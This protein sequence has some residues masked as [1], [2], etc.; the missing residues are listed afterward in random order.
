MR[1]RDFVDAHMKQNKFVSVK[2]SRWLHSVT[3]ASE[4]WRWLFGRFRLYR[5]GAAMLNCSKYSFFHQTSALV[6]MEKPQNSY[7][8]ISYLNY[9]K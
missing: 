6:S 1:E 3:P 5:T 9:Y 2:P 8:T 4:K 7:K